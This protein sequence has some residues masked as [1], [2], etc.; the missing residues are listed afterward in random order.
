MDPDERLNATIIEL[1]GGVVDAQLEL[2]R[3][4]ENSARGAWQEQ[5]SADP[6]QPAKFCAH[7]FVAPGI[8]AS[9]VC[10]DALERRD[11]D[12]MSFHPDDESS[13]SV[14]NYLR[15]FA[16]RQ[17]AM[18]ERLLHGRLLVVWEL[19]GTE[20]ANLRW[21]F[22]VTVRRDHGF[23]P[24][25]QNPIHADTFDGT[26]AAFALL[27]TKVPTPIYP[28][29]YFHPSALR[30]F[31]GE[32]TGVSPLRPDRI[33]LARTDDGMERSGPARVQRDATLVVFPPSVAHC[34]PNCDP[35]HCA[36]ANG[37]GEPFAVE[38]DA[39]W[40]CRVSLELVPARDNTDGGA[41]G[42]AALHNWPSIEIRKRAAVL[43]AEHV[44]GD[45]DFAMRAAA[46]MQQKL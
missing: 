44:W 28:A 22:I 33:R 4:F 18:V 13:A 14:F 30:Q 38:A 6:L 35:S 23:D 19:L 32:V 24:R 27:S 42:Q 21:H 5:L 26:M 29:A 11:T 46:L 10:H 17:C 34:V 43:I 8:M 45:P 2:L 20:V 3:N 25:E 37:R 31:V 16:A 12:L 9:A 7:A 1:S 41:W 39:R 15:F 40:F 36:S